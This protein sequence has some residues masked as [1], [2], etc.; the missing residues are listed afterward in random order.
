MP[1]WVPISYS[2]NNGTGH[3]SYQ[4]ETA[5]LP[6]GVHIISGELHRGTANEFPN[7]KEGFDDQSPFHHTI[8]LT[9]LYLKRCFYI[10][11]NF[12]RLKQDFIKLRCHFF[13]PGIA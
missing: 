10:I 2:G 9:V 8:L 6:F 13:R 11:N 4:L 1:A 7:G 12:N 5:E 3:F